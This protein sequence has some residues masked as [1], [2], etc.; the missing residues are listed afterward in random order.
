VIGNRYLK[1]IA[2][3]LPNV[4]E[5]EILELAEACLQQYDKKLK[6]IER[7]ED[8]YP[9]REAIREVRTPLANGQVDFDKA[10]R[11]FIELCRSKGWGLDDRLDS[12]FVVHCKFISS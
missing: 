1:L 6:T 3:D 9:S 7:M 10:V 4:D 8:W 12:R 5:A 2:D 11:T